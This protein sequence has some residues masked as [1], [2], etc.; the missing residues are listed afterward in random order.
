ML[1]TRFLR[2]PGDMGNS[3]S[4]DF[5]VHCKVVRGDPRQLIDLFVEGGRDLVA[6]GAD[7]ITTN[8]GFLSLIQDEVKQALGVPDA[9]SSLMQVAM[10][11]TLLSAD[12]Y[13][14]ILTNSKGSLTVAHL[15]AAGVDPETP[16]AGTESGRCFTRDVLADAQ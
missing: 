3:M 14:R 2:I 10:V 13:C 12:K 8:C 7:V 11:E 4:R 15:A 9:S 5:P 6:I 16:V 1:E